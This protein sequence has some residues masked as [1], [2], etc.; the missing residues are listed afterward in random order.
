MLLHA[1]IYTHT[2]AHRCVHEYVPPPVILFCVRERENVF[3]Y[4]T[5]NGSESAI[6]AKCYYNYQNQLSLWQKS[7]QRATLIIIHCC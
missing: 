2:R 5:Q 1:H 3:S 7:G 6:V 4:S